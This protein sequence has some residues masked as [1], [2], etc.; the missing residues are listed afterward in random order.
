MSFR[1]SAHRRSRLLVL[2]VLRWF[3]SRQAGVSS[4]ELSSW[5]DSV[6]HQVGSF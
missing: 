1:E 6:L 5:V 3:A 2:P 4:A